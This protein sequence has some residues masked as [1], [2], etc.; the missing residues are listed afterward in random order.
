MVESKHSSNFESMVKNQRGLCQIIL[1][2]FLDPK[3]L[4]KFCQ[5]NKNCNQLLDPKSKYCV[6]FKVLYWE[7]F[8]IQITPDEV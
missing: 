4:A 5:I 1:F 3:E 8:G 2:L 6:N 7:Q